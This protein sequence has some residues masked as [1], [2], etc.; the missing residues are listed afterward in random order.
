LLRP[1][2][3]VVVPK[4]QIP[5]ARSFVGV[6]MIGRANVGE[7]EESS[8]LAYRLIPP[9]LLKAALAEDPD[10]PG[11]RKLRVE[12]TP[13]VLGVDLSPVAALKGYR[14]VGRK[15]GAEPS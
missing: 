10:K 7:S 2:R 14:L 9:T 11:A 4:A 8:L 13:P 12:W 5:A 6:L 1:L 15:P 3:G